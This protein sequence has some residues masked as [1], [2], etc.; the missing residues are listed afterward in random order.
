MKWSREDAK[1]C[2]CN[3]T[4][5]FETQFQKQ[6]MLVLQNKCTKFIC[7]QTNQKFIT[8]NYIPGNNVYTADETSSLPKGD[9]ETLKMLLVQESL[10]FGRTS[11]SDS[12]YV[13]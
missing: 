12:F 8:E 10:S 2:Y 7:I 5:M 9:L 4:C 11:K 1:G 13:A 3:R 6:E